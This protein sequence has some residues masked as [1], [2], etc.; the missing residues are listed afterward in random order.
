MSIEFGEV[1][2]IILEY[3][4]LF[5]FVIFFFDLFPIDILNLLQK[6]FSETLH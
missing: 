6:H 4:W 3:E 2:V 5:C 1:I